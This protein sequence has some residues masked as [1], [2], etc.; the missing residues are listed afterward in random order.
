MAALLAWWETIYKYKHGKH[1]HNQHKHFSLFVLSVN[2]IY[3]RGSLVVLY[4][5]DLNHG[6]ENGRTHFT[7]MGLYK[8]L[9]HNRGCK[10]IFMYE[11]LTP[12][13][14]AVQGAILGPGIKTQ[15]GTLNCTP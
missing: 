7:R 4:Q 13:S 14:P 8:W 5:T 15:V 9:N 6:S 12:Q 11:V 3:G 10:I 1:C 2:G